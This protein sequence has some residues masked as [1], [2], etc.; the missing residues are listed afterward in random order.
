MRL[1]PA[2]KSAAISSLPGLPKHCAARRCRPAAA[3]LALL[4]LLSCGAAAGPLH[5]QNLLLITL[6]GLR[7]QEVFSGADTGL[8][9]DRRYVDDTARLKEQFATE[10]PATRRRILMPFFWDVIGQRGQL[11]GNRRYQNRVD[12]GNRHRLAY[13]GYNEMLSGASDDRRVVGDAR[14][15]NP[16]PTVLE[17][18]G[19]QP[20]F[21]GRVAAFASWREMPWVLAERRSGIPVNAGWREATAQPLSARE[22]TLNQLQRQIP[23]PWR[24]ARHD[25][26]THH[27][28][29]EYLK[30]RRPR[31]LHI[32]Y[33]D[34]DNSAHDGRYDA[35]LLAIRRQDAFVRELWLWLQSDAQYRGRTTL[36]ITTPHGRGANARWVD[37]GERIPGAEAVWLAVIGP[38]TPARGEMQRDMQLMLNQIAPTAAALLGLAFMPGSGIAS[39]WQ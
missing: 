10:S 22:Q 26:F 14:Q 34:A 11:Y 32:A 6:E 29:L 30:K 16:N 7:W 39:V 27:Y 33:G 23:P 5:T 19:R 15:V 17:W 13:P 37:H 8:L 2:V 1:I 35:Y 20:A 24:R 9:V 4:S 18:A 21:S 25:A 31:L 3:R 38:D 28:A 12:A 36:L